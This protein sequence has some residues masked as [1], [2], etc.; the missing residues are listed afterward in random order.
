MTRTAADFEGMGSTSLEE[1]GPWYY[2]MQ[3]LGYN[4]RITDIQCALG[5][6]Q[7]DRIDDFVERRRQ[8]VALYND[9][10]ES[11]DF[12][13]TPRLR[14]ER[15]R[16]LTSWHLYTLSVD[17]ESLGKTRSEVMAELRGQ[18]VFTQ[19]LYI[20]VHLQPWYSRTYGYTTGKCPAAENY[21]QKAL[22]I[23]LYPAMTHDDVT[24]VIQCVKNLASKK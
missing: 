11:L 4:Y 18:S 2:E 1:Q 13:K 20:P 10:F 5:I 21:Y 6:S 24:H 12:L 15:D 17:F 14:N 8:I 23:P 7:L 9:A 19:V 22:S 3:S 16:E